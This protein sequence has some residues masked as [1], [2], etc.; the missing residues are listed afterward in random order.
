MFED[1]RY[2]VTKTR[3]Y[4]ET[5]MAPVKIRRYKIKQIKTLQVKVNGK[6]IDVRAEEDHDHNN[7]E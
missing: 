5:G 4:N 1:I 6:W 2:L 7:N 3:E